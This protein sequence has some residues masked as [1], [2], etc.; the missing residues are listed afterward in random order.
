MKPNAIDVIEAAY[1]VERDERSWLE[2]ILSAAKPNIDAGMGAFAISYAAPE[3]T[4]FELRT[5][6]A[7]GCPDVLRDR[8]AFVMADLPPTFIESGRHARP[9]AL[10]S[11]ME[12]FRDFTAVAEHLHPIGAYD[13]FGINVLDPTGF[14]CYVGAPLPRRRMGKLPAATREIWSCVAAHVASGFRMQRA[15]AGSTSEPDA[16]LDAEG[17]AHHAKGQATEAE[18][19]ETLKRAAVA[20]DRAR[21]PMRA[22]S[23][24]SAIREW[25]GLVAA[26][27]TLLE[28]FESDGRRYLV[29]R[30]NDPAHAYHLLARRERQVLGYALLG[31]ENKLIA[32]ELGLSASTVRVLFSR[33]AKKLG[34]VTRAETLRRFAEGKSSSEDDDD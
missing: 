15:L 1:D 29:A 21:G 26:R 25:K 24:A 9:C 7:L 34:T 2:G 31:H 30:R 5:M 28:V 27:W 33:A 12:G 19:L 8:V 22:L 11:E 14:G 4:S 16:V 17:R 32:Y 23:P 6:A 3:E 10:A 13:V 20:M 18:A